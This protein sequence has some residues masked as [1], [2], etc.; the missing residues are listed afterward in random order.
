MRRKLMIGF[1]FRIENVKEELHKIE[2]LPKDFK[3]YNYLNYFLLKEC[4]ISIYEYISMYKN[5]LVEYENIQTLV[6]F[7]GEY[8]LFIYFLFI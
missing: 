1:K 5:A 6:D 4:L 7:E 8:Y 2:S 3:K